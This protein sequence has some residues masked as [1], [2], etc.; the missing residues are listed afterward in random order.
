MG[1]W[2]IHSGAVAGFNDYRIGL[3]HTDPYS[4]SYYMGTTDPDSTYIYLGNSDYVNDDG[5]SYICYAWHEVE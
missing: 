2:M 5:D 4:G 3:D 1:H